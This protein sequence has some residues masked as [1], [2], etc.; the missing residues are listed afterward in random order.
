MI[1]RH[2]LMLGFGL[3]LMAA[4]TLCPAAAQQKA[5]AP[6]QP[7]SPA[8]AAAPITPAHLAAARALVIGS[9]MSRSFGVVIPQFVDQIGSS[10]S[11][12][13]PEIVQDLKEVLTNLRPEFEKQAD[14]MT[15]IA[16]QI[17]AKRLSE[18]DLN[19]AVAFFNS[20]AGKNYVAAQPAILTDIVTAMQGWQG[21]IST[22]M[23]TRVR[24]EMKKKGHDI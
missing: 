2:E 14:E 17:F 13:R 1:A 6:A 11:Q 12:T 19:A 7:A 23:M 5:P 3:A 16:A 15:D 22:D 21:K 8:P 24:E 20:T 18:A 10:L 9:G 4:A